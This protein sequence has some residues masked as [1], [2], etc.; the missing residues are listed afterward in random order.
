MPEI[1]IKGTAY[2]LRF[3]MGF[4]REI[5]ETFTADAGGIPQKAGLK[6]QVADMADGSL[7]ALETIILCAAKT[8]TPRLTQDIL[9]E[10]MENLD[11]D[12]DKL[13]DDVKGFLLNS[14]V[15]KKVTAQILSAAATLA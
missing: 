15:A 12:L 1:I 11:T 10:Y 4:L 3:G 14:N 6:Y 13:R 9:D 7:E 5:N 8:E 2:P